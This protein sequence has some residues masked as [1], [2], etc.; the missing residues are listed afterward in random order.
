MANCG[1]A[2]VFFSRL[3]RHPWMAAACLVLGAVAI[4]YFTIIFPVERSAAKVRVALKEA[5]P[6]TRFD[7]G[8]GAVSDTL[9]H[10]YIDVEVSFVVD[11]RKQREMRD[12]LARW[13]SDHELTVGIALR[14]RDPEY[15]Y[16][17]YPDH[18]RWLNQLVL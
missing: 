13:K 14:F 5:Y 7:V 11:E 1:Q 17:K 10:Y 15:H 9:D 18:P 2:K 12:W 3:K 4:G 6:G 8:V 16:E